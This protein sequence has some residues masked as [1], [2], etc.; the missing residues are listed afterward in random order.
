MGAFTINQECELELQSL[1]TLFLLIH[2]IWESRATHD[3]ANKCAHGER[4]HRA[5]PITPLLENEAA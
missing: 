2:M 1:S 3:T 4:A 5:N